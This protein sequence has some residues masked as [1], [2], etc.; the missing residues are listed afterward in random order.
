MGAGSPPLSAPQPSVQFNLGGTYQNGTQP[1][2]TSPVSS[3]P[4]LPPQSLS[5]PPSAAPSRG[6]SK[7]DQ[8]HAQ[9]ANLFAQRTD[10]GMDT[11]GNV[12][13]LRYGGQAGKTLVAQQTG[14]THNPFYQQQQQQLQQQQQ[15]QQQYGGQ[16]SDQPFFSI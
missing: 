8:D 4:P 9:L 13:A 3:P 7:A 14:A 11:F 1:S 5:A 15:Q 2:F 16:S 6:P 12:G 10:D